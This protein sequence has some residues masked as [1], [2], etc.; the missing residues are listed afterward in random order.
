MIVAIMMVRACD[1]LLTFETETIEADE[2]KENCLFVDTKRYRFRL[3]Q[4]DDDTLVVLGVESKN[5]GYNPLEHVLG[6]LGHA[7]DGVVNH[8]ITIGVPLAIAGAGASATLAGFGAAGIVGG[9]VAAAIQSVI[10]NVASGSVFATMQSLGATGV[11]TAMTAGGSVATAGSAVVL[12]V[13]NGGENEEKKEESTGDDGAKK[14]AT[15]G[16]KEGD[17]CDSDEA[18]NNK[19]NAL[20]SRGNQECGLDDISDLVGSRATISKNKKLLSILH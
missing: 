12:A 5:S 19:G 13:T 14:K 7:K 6:V 15:K 11:F 3:Y 8:P 9:S 20:N 18:T 17:T 10:G 2:S 1:A 16:N 4:L